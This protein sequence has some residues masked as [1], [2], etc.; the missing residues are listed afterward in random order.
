MSDTPVFAPDPRP[1]DVEGTPVPVSVPA[2]DPRPT[3][4][5]GDDPIEN[6][7]VTGR[8]PE[9]SDNDISQDPNFEETE[10]E[11]DVNE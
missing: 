10:W 4:V 7:H 8:L 6:A 11:G 9:D 2:P 1:V 5:E 3:D